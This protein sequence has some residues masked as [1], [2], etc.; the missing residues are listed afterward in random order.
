MSS[1]QVKTAESSRR[2]GGRRTA[3]SPARP[4][5]ASTGSRSTSTPARCAPASSGKVTDT[6]APVRRLARGDDGGGGGRARPV[7][8]ARSAAAA[9]P[10]WRRSAPDRLDTVSSEVVPRW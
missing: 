1:G 6:P 2:G 8:G 3:R 9:G 7:S 4:A 10:G 5:A